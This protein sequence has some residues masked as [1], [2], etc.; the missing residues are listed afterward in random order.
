MKIVADESVDGGIVWLLRQ[1]GHDVVYIAELDPG[2]S[3]EIVLSIASESGVLLVTADKDFGELVFRQQLTH[4]GVML[5][6]LA[7]LS[8]EAKPNVVAA[9]IRERGPE[10]ENTF[11]VVSPGWIR[12]RRNP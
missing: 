6:R 1:E 5:I 8:P 4:S 12:I 3:D 9:A 10:L 11:S 2:I 7:G